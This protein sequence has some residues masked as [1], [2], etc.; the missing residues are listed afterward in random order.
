MKTTAGFEPAILVEGH[1]V[2][3][4]LDAGHRREVPVTR[5]VNFILEVVRSTP[6]LAMLGSVVPQ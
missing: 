4:V 5:R 1:D 2:A 6:G 3:F